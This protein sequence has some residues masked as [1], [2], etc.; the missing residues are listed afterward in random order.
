[1]LKNNRVVKFLFTLT[2]TALVCNLA[3]ANQDIKTVE[4]ANNVQPVA[5]NNNIVSPQ[6][7]SI[8]GKDYFPNSTLIT[9]D[10][11]EVKFFDDVIKDKVVA[12]NFIYTTC[13]DSCPLETARMKDVKSILGD[14]VGKDIHFYSISI[15][16]EFDSPA[17]LKAY[18]KKFNI[19]DDWTFLTG[20]QKDITNLRKKLGLYIDEI[21]T[22]PADLE[23]HN[24]NLIIGNQST[25]RWMKRTPFENP[26]I[27][28]SH[29]G[30][31]LHNW[32]TV[33]TINNDYADA[34][35]LRQLIPGEQ[36]FRTRC[37]SCHDIGKDSVGPD[38]FAVTENRDRTWLTRWLKE[39]DKML[40]EKDPLAMSLFNKYKIP[41]PNMRLT[42]KD[43]EDVISYLAAETERLR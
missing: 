17:V 16:P 18:K 2:A 39:P 24:L 26:H 20:N 8:W 31:W 37:S 41:M 28:A 14:R 4:Q 40:K 5:V 25:G 19:G 9:Q 13:D 36:L 43:V 42:D 23:D 35:R 33:S 22:D 1:M 12:I 32:K 15:D 27:L 11:D 34:P 6:K 3:L 10:G 7:K 29:L 38:L 21:N 30:D